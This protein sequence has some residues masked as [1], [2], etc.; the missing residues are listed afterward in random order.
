MFFR[1]KTSGVVHFMSPLILLFATCDLF[2]P[3]FPLCS[4]CVSCMAK[5][6][7]E[8]SSWLKTKKK[9]APKKKM[10]DGENLLPKLHKL[11]A[12]KP[13]YNNRYIEFFEA[14]SLPTYCAQRWPPGPSCSK[15]G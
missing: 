5:Y 13:R 14:L 9:T 10:K 1:G 12:H 4:I 11:V 7:K 15:A 8:K 3:S 2:T 6:T